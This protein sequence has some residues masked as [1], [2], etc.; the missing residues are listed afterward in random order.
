MKLNAEDGGS[1]RFIL[2]ETEDYA[3]T[4]TAERIRRASKGYGE[5]DKAVAGLGSGFSYYE[6]GPAL[7]DVEGFAPDAPT[8]ARRSFVWY[9]ETGSPLGAEAAAS[10]RPYL[11]ER[12]GA[13]YYLFESSFGRAAL[14]ELRPGFGTHV[15]YGPACGLGPSFLESHGIIFKK[16]PRDLPVEGRAAWS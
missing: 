10:D 15:V 7:F 9:A 14:R 8:T 13:A 11:G 1:R 5:G 2:V 16:L 12:G 6:L 3:E 4:L